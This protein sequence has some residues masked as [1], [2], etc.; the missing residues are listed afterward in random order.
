M[1]LFR[2]AYS[3]V[4]ALLLLEYLA[5]FFLIAAAIFTV[6]AEYD[7]TAKTAARALSD[8]DTYFGLHAINGLIVIGVTTLVLIAL[9]FGAR[10]SWR[11]TGLTALLLLL[12]ALQSLLAHTGIALVS[13]VHA[14]NGL[15]MLGLAGGLLRSH[16]AFGAPPAATP[17]EPAVSVGT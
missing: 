11:T 3:V 2:K 6:A 17:A 12:L 1:G 15:A 14:L 8:A 5:Q 9:S 16:W 7:G 10:H 4:G 13:A